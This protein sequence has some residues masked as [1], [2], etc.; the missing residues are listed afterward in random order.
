LTISGLQVP[1]VAGSGAP[2]IQKPVICDEIHGNTGLDGAK[3]PPLTVSA[4]P[5]STKA[6]SM[7]AETLKKHNRVTLLATGPLTNIALLLLVYPECKFFIE[8]IVIMGGALGLGNTSPAAEFN[9]QVDPDAAHIVFESGLP[10][11]MVPLEVTHTALV[12]PPVVDR[13]RVSLN[14]SNF[15]AVILDLLQF[16]ESTYQKVF[17]FSSPPLH[18]PCACALVF[19]PEIFET[20]LMR[21][22]QLFIYLN[23]FS[24]KDIERNSEFCSGRTVCDIHSF[25]PTSRAKNANVALQMNVEIFWDLMISALCRANER[26]PLNQAKI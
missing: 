22:V 24:S 3:F 20:K 2:L 11:F 13:I 10:L 5:P 19:E 6:I 9:I 1:V 4:E 25:K 14:D 8:K 26:S 17:G 7:I 23:I 12:T 18:D 16:F 21:V 15:C